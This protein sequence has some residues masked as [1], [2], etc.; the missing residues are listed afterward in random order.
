VPFAEDAD[1]RFGFWSVRT[2]RAGRVTDARYARVATLRGCFG[3]TDKPARQHFQ[4]EIAIGNLTMTG[5]G[6]CEALQ[7]DVPENGLFP[8][9]CQLVLG[10]LPAPYVGGLLTTN[11]MTSSASFG[12]ESDPPGYAQASIATIRLWKRRPPISHHEGTK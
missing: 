8:V 9:R 5:R 3:A 6:E 11:T 1:R 7:V 2:D 4:A 12:G 10:D